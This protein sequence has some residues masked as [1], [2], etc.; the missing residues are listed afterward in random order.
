MYQGQSM[1]S[2]QTEL[3]VSDLGYHENITKYSLGEYKIKAGTD[4]D[5][6]P[7]DFTDLMEFTKFVDSSTRGTTVETWEKHLDTDSFTRS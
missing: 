4:G 7:K 5:A 2:K 6:I 3:A 1:S